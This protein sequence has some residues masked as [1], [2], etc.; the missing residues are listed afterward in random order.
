MTK[1][2]SLFK[3][4]ALLW[5]S[6]TLFLLLATA[7]GRRSL[8]LAAVLSVGLLAVL[9]KLPL[10]RAGLKTELGF[11]YPV[12]AVLINA[13]A[14][15]SFYGKMRAE[16]GPQQWA[17]AWGLPLEPLLAVC[18]AVLAVLSV[19]FVACAIGWA[20]EELL[21]APAQRLEAAA[22]GWPRKKAALA[23]GLVYLVALLPLL[24]ANFNYIDDLGRAYSGY[25]YFSFNRH[26][27][28]LLSHFVHAGSFLADISPLTQLLA[29]GLL[30]AASLI[31]IEQFGE[32]D[33]I[34]LRQLLAAVPLGL[35]PYYLQCLSYKYDSPYM[36]LSV[37]A[38]V[39]PL[40]FRKKP[41]WLYAG[42][43]AFCTLVLCMTYQASAG[44]FP[45]CVAL[46]AWRQWCRKEPLKDTGVFI[47]LSA[48]GYLAGMG[49]F[50]AVIMTP[51]N[52]Y[53]SNSLASVPTILQNY[54]NYFALLLSDFKPSW[55]VL[56]AVLT[57]WFVA[58]G[59]RESRRPRLASLLVTLAAV[60]VLALLAFGLYPALEVP[61]TDPRG[62]YGVGVYLALVGLANPARGKG[63]QVS[64]L[65]NAVLAW[66]FVV[67]A[68]TYGNALAYQKEYIDFRTEEIVNSLAHVEA[69]YTCAE[70]TVHIEGSAGYAIAVE[71]SAAGCGILKRLVPLYLYGD[72]TWGVRK[73]QAYYGLTLK[74]DDK[75]S[76]D[77][78]YTAWPVLDESA[79]HTIYGKDGYFVIE[80]K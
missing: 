1:D 45:M 10:T 60:C 52:S 53:V 20:R 56:G 70:P 17:A 49:F 28:D 38:A 26:I 43:I 8:P 21:A 67:F 12:F 58:A 76:G 78:D 4:K 68:C 6:G 77:G 36:A 47:G 34:S 80:L 51:V 50:Y 25:D 39:A 40:L 48:A 3:A 35:S 72:N 46:L 15:Y 24:R 44:I 11:P 65:L 73:F 31:L 63:R 16:A 19:P 61:S 9:C 18:G 2:A 22:Q 29:V 74:Y 5:G 30:V 14:A 37:L 41:W 13:A 23:L 27:S 71:N 62:M 54:R 33:G 66:C 32:E 7:G 55:L 59:V 75:Y 69:Y 42:S 57:V 79:Y 64:W